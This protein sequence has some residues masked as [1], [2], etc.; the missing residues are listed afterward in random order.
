[1]S[2]T[3]SLH[4]GAVRTALFAWLFARH[5]GGRFVLRIEDT[6]QA[7][8]VPDSQSQIT[9]SLEWLGLTW[10]EGPGVGGPHDPYVQSQRTDLYREHGEM[11]AEQGAAYWCTC[12][13]ERLAG[14]RAAQQAARQPTRY[15]RRCLER[16]DEVASERRAGAPAVLR[17]RMPEGHTEWDDAVAG[18]LA[19]ENAS[20]D[21][22][23]L[24]KSDGYP[25]YHLAVVVDDH[26]MRISHVLRA[27]EWIPSTP[28]H[29]ALYR[30]FGWEPPVFAHLP[31][32]LGA[33]GKLKL[34]KRRGAKFILDYRDLGYL[35][36]AMINA[37]VLLG[38]SS[39]TET[40]LFTLDELVNAFT[41]ERVHPA[42][43]VFDEKR[44]DALNGLHIRM[45][46]H[47][48]LAAALQPWL[49]ALERERLLELVPLLQ[50]RMV[51]LDEAPPLVA[52]LI[53]SAPW[54]ANVQ[55][56]PKKVDRDTAHVLLTDAIE[57]IAGGGLE[58]PVAL[59]RR[60]TALLESRGVTAR[61]G[62]RTLYIAVL[63]RPAGLPVFD[64]MRYVGAGE[65]IARLQQALQRLG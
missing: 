63:G 20:I 53:G 27:T 55:F 39:G 45:L 62:F 26:L 28:K 58:D 7:R 61:D 32:V 21:D 11:L 38:W 18:H 33:D 8:Q 54:D 10:D 35:P 41:L 17:M 37:M 57:A 52:P 36:E 56:P 31:N 40:E 25:T 43:A 59:R 16:Q 64:A 1:V 47:D 13:P 19:F 60:L 5:A 15:D 48:R 30:A 49:P 34:S 22:Q 23:V 2:P 50:E 42:A 24:L 6:D 14:L 9:E 51:R 29:I 3:G 65:S 12:T 46:D 4:V 44:L